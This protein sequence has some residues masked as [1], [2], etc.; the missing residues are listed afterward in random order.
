MAA[1]LL[2][3]ALAARSEPVSVLSAGVIDGDRPVTPEVVAALLPYGIDLTGHRSTALEAPA[4]EG[5]DLVLG[6]ERR[7]CREAVLL[8]P[9]A[10]ARTFT[11]KALVRRGEKVGPRPPGHSLESWLGDAADGRERSDLIG[12]S[13]DDDVADPL[14]GPLDDYRATAA[15]LAGL[16][17][18]LAALL[19]PAPPSAD[20]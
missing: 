9:S 1:S 7:H 12:R 14:G 17:D 3:A 5:A 15:E 4:V 18:R 8:V 16:V 10:L 2:R 19:W 6:M 20:T 11:L 13:S